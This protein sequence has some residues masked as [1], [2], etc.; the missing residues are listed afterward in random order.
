MIEAREADQPNEN[1]LVIYYRRRNRIVW[2]RKKVTDPIYRGD[3]NLLYLQKSLFQL[4]TRNLPT[5]LFQS[6]FLCQPISSTKPH[7]T[8]S[9]LETLHQ[10]LCRAQ[11]LIRPD[12]QPPRKTIPRRHYRGGLSPSKNHQ[13]RPQPRQPIAPPPCQ[14]KPPQK[15]KR[16]YLLS[17]SPGINKLSPMLSPMNQHP[18]LASY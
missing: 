12:D 16:R 2:G 18:C 13:H 6:I 1:E 9:S 4:D 7:S 11:S 10:P 15:A 17:R 5:E 14:T 8:T 3:Q